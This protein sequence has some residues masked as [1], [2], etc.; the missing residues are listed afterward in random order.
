MPWIH[1][2]LYFHHDCH[3]GSFFSALLLG[4]IVPCP[5][6]STPSFSATEQSTTNVCWLAIIRYTMFSQMSNAPMM[7]AT[8]MSR[9]HFGN[10]ATC[11]GR[12][13]FSLSPYQPSASSKKKKKKALEKK[14]GGGGGYTPSTV[15]AMRHH[16][17]EDGMWCSSILY[18]TTVAMVDFKSTHATN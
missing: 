12:N 5:F 18:W 10:V 2:V 15:I 16:N 14:K 11:H 3:M 4:P 8:E 7:I 9:L 17:N 1:P 6:S 13:V